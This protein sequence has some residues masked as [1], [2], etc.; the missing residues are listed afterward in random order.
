MGRGCQIVAH[1]RSSSRRGLRFGIGR[2]AGVSPGPLSVGGG[3]GLGGNHGA[4][5][6]SPRSPGGKGS[7]SGEGGH[8]VEGQGRLGGPYL[9]TAWP[10]CGAAGGGPAR[11]RLH[12]EG[13]QR[14]VRA[15]RRLGM[16]SVCAEKRA[17]SPGLCVRVSAGGGCPWSL[18]GGVCVRARGDRAR[19]EPPPPPPPSVTARDR[20]AASP[21]CTRSASAARRPAGC[22]CGRGAASTAKPGPGP[23]GGDRPPPPPR[24]SQAWGGACRPMGDRGRG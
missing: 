23:E 7:R 10:R 21:V 3:R 11:G 18:R 22:A 6:R 24:T 4:G 15:P 12:G 20:S 17:P 5:R 19:L 2:L 1:E 9:L 16:G 8:A 13:A 14:R